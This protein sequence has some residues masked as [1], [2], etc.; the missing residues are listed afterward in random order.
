[1][2]THR[3]GDFGIA[4]RFDDNQAIVD[5]RG[6]LDMLTAPT[7]HALISA[8]CEQG[9]HEV[10]VDLSA[11]A[12]MDASGLR[13]I[14]DIATNLGKSNGSLTLRAASVQARRVIDATSVRSMV[15]HELSDPKVVALGAEQRSGDHSRA[16]DSTPAALSADIGRVGSRPT[17]AV[18]DAAL[19]LVHALSFRS[20]ATRQVLTERPLIAH[21]GGGVNA[22]RCRGCPTASDASELRKLG[23][24]ARRG[25]PG[26]AFEKHPRRRPRQRA[27]WA[28]GVSCAGACRRRC[29]H[30][31]SRT[32]RSRRGG[33]DR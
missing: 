16:V 17:E 13:V 1:M 9:H 32:A 23:R 30:G 24:R 14:A 7:L 19:R 5:V 33:R 29:A 26:E 3:Y 15:R 22:C 6:E 28:P 31:R 2:T 25:A 10:V 20:T 8:L 4:I 12:F 27:H 21:R 18:V 11:L